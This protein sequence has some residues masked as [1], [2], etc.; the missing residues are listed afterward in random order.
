[1]WGANASNIRVV[2]AGGAIRRYT[3]TW[4]NEDAS[5]CWT[6]VPNLFGIWGS[7]ESDV[8]VVG[9]GGT[10]CHF[11]G[12]DWER[13]WTGVSTEL[14]KVWGRAP[15]DV[16]AVGSGGLVLHYDGAQWW[17]LESGT[18]NDLGAIHG[19]STDLVIAGAGGTVR[20][21]AGAAL[22]VDPFEEARNYIRLSAASPSGVYVLSIGSV[23][24]RAATLDKRWTEVVPN[25]FNTE[26]AAIWADANGAG[27]VLDTFGSVHSS[28]NAWAPVATTLVG[29]PAGLEGRGPS[30]LYAFGESGGVAHYNGTWS[31]VTTTTDPFLELHAFSLG[32][33]TVWAVG[34]DGLGKAAKLVGAQWV[35]LPLPAQTQELFGVYAASDTSVFA[36]G[37]GG[38]ILHYDGTAWSPMVSGVLNDL[39][40]ISGTSETDVFAVGNNIVL[41]YDGSAW[42]PVA[43]PQGTNFADVAVTAREVYAL[44]QNYDPIRRTVTLMRAPSW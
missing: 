2:G 13:Q 35:D 42:S 26:Y 31:S 16:Y 44:S 32:P 40:A 6:S 1:V 8:F 23:W 14:H 38:V 19:S 21:Y 9:S 43:F 39:Y 28:T 30:D 18:P 36:V 12:T 34:K 33:T 29:V 15:N 7:S 17:S 5:A 3:G 24:Q 4:S 10:I 41:H 37:G 11:N 27:F 22:A 20:R 25:D